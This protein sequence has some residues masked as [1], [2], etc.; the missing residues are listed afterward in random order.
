MLDY[1]ELGRGVTLDA[2]PDDPN[3]ELKRKLEENKKGITDYIHSHLKVYVNGEAVDGELVQT[4]L[5]TRVGRLYANLVLEY[6]NPGNSEA[7]EVVYEI[8]F[9]DIDSLHRNIAA[10]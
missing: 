7:V 9:D 6:P 1:F 8:F 5:D 4:G 2:M 3:V 10:L